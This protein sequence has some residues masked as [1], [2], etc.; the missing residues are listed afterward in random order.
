[1]NKFVVRQPI[2]DRQSNLFGYEILFQGESE[3]LY[4]QTNDYQAA[5]TISDFLLQNSDKV[6]DEKMAFLTF[7]PNL[8]FRNTPKIFKQNNL[9][10]QIEDNVIIHPLAQTLITRYRNQGYYIAVNDFQFAPR[11]FAMMENIDYIKLNMEE[12]SEA[13]VSNICKMAKGFNK[14]CIAYGVNQKSAY[15]LAMEL[16]M[17]Y[18]QGAYIAETISQK[19][20]RMEYLQSNFFQ[21]VVAVTKED[22]DMDEIE[23]IISRD[24]A[25]TYAILKMV[26]S[27]YFALRQR[28]SSIKQAIMTLGLGQLKQ[29]VYLLSFKQEESAR[30]EELLKVSFLRA[31]FCSELAK[32]IKALPISRSEAYLMGM[33]STLGYLVEAPLEEALQEIPVSEEIKS[34]LLGGEGICGK[35]F[36]LILSYEKADWKQIALLAD[37]LGIPKQ[38]ISQVYFNCVEEVNGIWKNL[39]EGEQPGASHADEDYVET[40][41]EGEMEMPTPPYYKDHDKSGGKLDLRL[42]KGKKKEENSLN[43]ATIQVKNDSMTEEERKEREELLERANALIPKKQDRAEE[44]KKAALGEPVVEEIMDALPQ[45]QEDEELQ[46]EAAE[47]SKEE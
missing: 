23:E 27:V 9:V 18:L 17:D 33:F 28:T 35:L 10:I 38:M 4:N 3:N 39:M 31:N 15:D 37:E 32:S 46:L 24:A 19:V 47:E 16:E 21:L 29:W 45:L 36:S 1:M 41:D 5:D 34:A 40:E 22:A 43:G 25:L 6:F 20:H 8:L 44:F 42:G 12:L 30:N 26:N 2:K 13:S 7:T 14:K 11:Y